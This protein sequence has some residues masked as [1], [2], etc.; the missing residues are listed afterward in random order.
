MEGRSLV[1]HYENSEQGTGF[2]SVSFVTIVSLWFP[3]TDRTVVR[4][5]ASSSQESRKE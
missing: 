2:L 5:K 3:F 4:I 1:Q